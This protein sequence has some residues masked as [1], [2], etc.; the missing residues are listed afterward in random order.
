M[1]VNVFLTF[2][3][4]KVHVNMI[5]MEKWYFLACYGVPAVPALLYLLLDVSRGMEFYGDATVC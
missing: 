3:T 4:T 1:A 2:H 5:K